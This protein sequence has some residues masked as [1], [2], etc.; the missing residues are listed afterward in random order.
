VTPM[1][2]RWKE[3]LEKGCR[4]IKMPKRGDFIFLPHF[5]F[6]MRVTKVW[7]WVH[8]DTC[9]WFN[10]LSK[11]SEQCVILRSMLINTHIKTSFQSKVINV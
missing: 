6:G 4:K 2:R 3:R 1:R 11:Q 8:V 5:H 7:C 10:F 9:T